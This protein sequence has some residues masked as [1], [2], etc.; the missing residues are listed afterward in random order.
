[1]NNQQPCERGNLRAVLSVY[2]LHA[3]DDHGNTGDCQT[4]TE[5]DT[6]S[7]ES[8]YC[9]ACH[10][11]F[12]SFEVALGHLSSAAPLD[13]SHELALSKPQ[14]K[15]LLEV[16][17]TDDSRPALCRAVISLLRDDKPCLVATDGYVLA[18]LRL[19]DSY[20]HRLNECVLRDDLVKWYKLAGNR[21]TFDDDALREM[22][23]V[24]DTQFPDWQGAVPTQAA[25]TEVICFNAGYA[26]TLQALAG[27][28][29]TYRL[30][31]AGR[32]MVGENDIGSY[33][34][35]PLKVAA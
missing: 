23:V 31:G 34:L 17:S 6:D 32:A 22:L 14:V 15:A 35:M 28:S 9:S 29:V 27:N 10:Q 1:M 3:V 16:I 24:N 2:Q 30:A 8:Y 7:V 33:V 11:H 13:D 20:R 12:D 5:P 4:R 25:P 18:A 21:D 19:N 26:T